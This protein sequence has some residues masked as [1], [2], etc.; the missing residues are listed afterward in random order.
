MTE[1]ER[2]TEIHRETGRDIE[3]ER[4]RE[5]DTVR[6]RETAREREGQRQQDRGTETYRFNKITIQGTHQMAVDKEARA[7]RESTHIY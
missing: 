2:D 5:A 7:Y 1:R 6:E 3:I 4:Q